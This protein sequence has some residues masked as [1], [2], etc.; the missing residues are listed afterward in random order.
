MWTVV[1]D[2]SLTSAPPEKRAEIVSPIFGYDEI[3]QLQEVI[4]AVHRAGARTGAD[5]G[6]HVHV[7]HPAITRTV[8]VDSELLARIAQRH[9]SERGIDVE[10][11]LDAFTPLDGSMS[12]A[13]VATSR[14]DEIVLV[15]GDMPLE[16]RLHRRRRVVLYASESRIFDAAIAIFPTSD[17]HAIFDGDTPADAAVGVQCL[18]LQHGRCQ[19]SLL[20]PAPRLFGTVALGEHYLFL[21]ETGHAC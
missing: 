16:I 9:T 4:R 18:G 10:G 5:A 12:L 2:S 19:L 3:P 15:K 21:L 20:L 8:Q 13:L 14:P 6:L 11:F 1:A 17:L 7:S